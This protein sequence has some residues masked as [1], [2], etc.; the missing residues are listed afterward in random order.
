M[1]TI[2]ITGKLLKSRSISIEGNPEFSEL[3][4][5][6]NALDTKTS[7]YDLVAVYKLDNT[8]VSMAYNH[9]ET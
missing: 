5:Y 7:G 8:T 2:E 4:F 1:Y 6:T 9:N 3:A